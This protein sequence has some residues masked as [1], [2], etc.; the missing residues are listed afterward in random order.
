[1]ICWERIF[2]A[3]REDLMLKEKVGMFSSRNVGRA[4]FL[5]V[6]LSMNSELSLYQKFGHT[7]FD[8]FLFACRRTFLLSFYLICQFV[9]FVVIVEQTRVTV[10]HNSNI[11]YT[12]S[13]K[14]FIVI[15]GLCFV[16]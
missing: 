2:I 1:M 13:R 4:W 12:G 7:L 14:W 9:S 8:F 10:V 5:Y 6:S 11:A 3:E 16:F 15:I